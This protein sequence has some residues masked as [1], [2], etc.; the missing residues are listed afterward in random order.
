MQ[1]NKTIEELQERWIHRTDR[2]RCKI[3]A[4][5]A[6]TDRTQHGKASIVVSLPLQMKEPEKFADATERHMQQDESIGIYYDR[7]FHQRPE[8]TGCYY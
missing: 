1:L 4:A 7:R 3:C 6:V 2:Y 5:G 8:C